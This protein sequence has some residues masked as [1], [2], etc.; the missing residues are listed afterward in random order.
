MTEHTDH[1]HSFWKNKQKSFYDTTEQK[2]IWYQPDSVFVTDMVKKF[3]AFT[4]IPLGAKILDVG[5]GAGRYSIP[6]IRLGYQITGIDL[7]QRLLDKFNE[8]AT[9]C[10]LSSSQYE[11]CC[12]DVESFAMERKGVFDA[13]IGFNIL[14]HIFDLD[15]CFSQIGK[16][17]KKGGIV[18]FIEPNAYNPL[19]IIDISLD[20]RWQAEGNI[21]NSTPKNLSKHL[22]RNAYCDVACLRFGFFPPF[23]IDSIPVMARLEHLVERSRIFEY[24]L[25]FFII[26]GCK[27]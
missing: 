1:K 26:K 16:C 18:G 3:L 27:K 22:A 17:L 12:Q 10:K 2:R 25:T 6:L 7:S 15:Y 23:V 19:H 9:N 24:L 11:L 20:R 5:C 13:V 8:D 21:R 14:H 4:E